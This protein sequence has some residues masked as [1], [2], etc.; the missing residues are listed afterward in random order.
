MTITPT[1]S[2]I[3]NIAYEEGALVF[4]LGHSYDPQSKLQ[5][6]A[7]AYETNTYNIQAEIT[8]VRVD[9]SALL[10]WKIRTYDKLLAA[11]LESVAKYEARVAGA[12]S[13]G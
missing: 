12:Q 9:E 1:P 10:A 2:S 5:L 7:F 3:I 6:N 8:F 4:P 13:R 11:Y